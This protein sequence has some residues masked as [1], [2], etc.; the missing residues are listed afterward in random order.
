MKKILVALAAVI[1]LAPAVASAQ[2]DLRIRVPLPPTPPLV[3][4]TPGVQVVEN[5]DEEVFFT[6]GYYWV[7]RSDRWYRAP[8]P[9]AEFA[10]VEHRAVPATLLK[11]PPGQYRRYKRAEHRAHKAEEREHREHRKEHREHQK[12]HRKEHRE[13]HK[14]HKHHGK[15]R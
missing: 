14:E 5:H 12:E 13:H 10:V 15:H 4:V 3:V 8:R 11:M 1:A 2:L 9:S 6:G 7:R